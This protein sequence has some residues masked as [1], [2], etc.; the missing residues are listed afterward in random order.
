MIVAQVL[1]LIKTKSRHHQ[2]EEGVETVTRIE[3]T[4]FNSTK[5]VRLLARVP[6]HGRTYLLHEQQPRRKRTSTALSPCYQ[7]TSI[8][9]RSTPATTNQESFSTTRNQKKAQE[10][11]KDAEEES[12]SCGNLCTKTM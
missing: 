10:T 7:E 2:R 11:R 6:T 4:Y 12:E 8:K 3:A 9:K 5:G 1:M